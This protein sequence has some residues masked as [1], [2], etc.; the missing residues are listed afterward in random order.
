MLVAVVRKSILSP[1][2]KQNWL[3]CPISQ[4][5]LF[6]LQIFWSVKVT[7]YQDNQSTL[8]LIRSGKSNSEKTRHIAIRFFFVADRVSSKDIKLEYMRTA[9]MLADILT[10][11]LQGL[12][13][14]EARKQ[15]LNWYD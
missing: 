11:P 9:D 6:E 15:L 4:V 13:F 2:P 3:N 1:V 10:K 7:M 8:A 5:K 12:K 14:V